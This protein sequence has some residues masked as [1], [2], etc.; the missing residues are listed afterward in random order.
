VSG[1][2]SG[3]ANSGGSGSGGAASGC[4]TAGDCPRENL[5][6]ATA[7]VTQCLAPGQPAPPTG[8]G[9]AGWCGQCNCGP[10]PQTPIGN[11]MPCQTSTDCPA[12]TAS[13]S[14]ASVCDMGL[15]AQ[16]ATSADCPATAHA[17]STVRGSFTQS[18]RLC[19]E[20]ALDTDCP[21]AKPRCAV[22]GGIGKCVACA[23]D[24]DCATGV[25]SNSACVP[26]CS[27]QM[28]CASPLTR[29]GA[30]QRCEA[31]TCQNDDTCPMNASCQQGQCARRS[32]TK[33]SDCDGGSCVNSV[34]YE[35][36]GTCY[37]QMLYP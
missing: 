28:P 26:G 27:A 14:T 25:C 16:C 36:L 6:P 10:Q 31:L 9:A 12:A 20:C 18:F 37:T 5:N 33:D 13:F 35:T 7:G 15:C 11:G 8:C 2:S 1:A 23:S 34:C 32:C 29:C 24:N 21:S 4:H 22:S 17:C 3:G 19:V 30:T